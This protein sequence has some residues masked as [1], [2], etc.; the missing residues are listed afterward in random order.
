MSEPGEV[1]WQ[2]PGEDVCRELDVRNLVNCTLM[3][4]AFLVL[5]NRRAVCGG[6]GGEMGKGKERKRHVRI[7][8]ICNY[9]HSIIQSSLWHHGFDP[10]IIPYFFREAK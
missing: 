6:V 7:M 3:L 4:S 8:A 1:S 2:T 5:T 9:K 10:P